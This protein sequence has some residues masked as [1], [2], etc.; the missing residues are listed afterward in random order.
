VFEKL[1]DPR[2]AAIS[3]PCP[4][5]LDLLGRVLD[6]NDRPVVGEIGIGIGATSLALCRALDH[7][8]EIWFF[9]F[10]DRL[11]EL[12]EDLRQAGF[13]NFRVFPNSRRSADSYAWTLAMQLRRAQTRPGAAPGVFDFVYL[14]GAHTFQHDAPATVCVKE[15]VKPGGYLLMDDYDWTIAVSP[16]MRPSVNPD[17]VKHFTEEQIELS[18]V[19]MV[20]SLFL[21]TDPR[22]EKVPIG[23]KNRE[24]RRAYRRLS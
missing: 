14:D 10:E 22:Y 1:A 20:C 24:H 8:G 18:H 2:Y 19:E 23:Y 11:A 4:Q 3:R 13:S 5:A 21:D 15:M 7:R 9:D 17:I 12:S 16:T 6:G